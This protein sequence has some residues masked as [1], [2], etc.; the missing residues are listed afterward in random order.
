MKEWSSRSNCSMVV[1][2]S[3]SSRIGVGMSRSAG[4]EV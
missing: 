2:A 1:Y 3:Q 4:G